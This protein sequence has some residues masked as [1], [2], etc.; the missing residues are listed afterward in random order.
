MELKTVK[1]KVKEAND[2]LEDIHK[3]NN[4]FRN[5]LEKVGNKHNEIINAKINQNDFYSMLQNH[6]DRIA[7][8]ECKL[9]SEFEE[10]KPNFEIKKTGIT[11]SQALNLL[12]KGIVDKIS[13]W[14]YDKI[15]VYL[16]HDLKPGGRKCLYISFGDLASLYY[17]PSHFDILESTWRVVE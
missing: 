15:Y 12:Q 3:N 13:C 7:K 5:L 8:L 14:E 11:F 16:S 6:E 9:K 4:E 2:A 1:E 17:T 10:E